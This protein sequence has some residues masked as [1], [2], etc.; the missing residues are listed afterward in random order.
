LQQLRVHW[1]SEKE[2]NI[3]FITLRSTAKTKGAL[4]FYIGFANMPQ[5]LNVCNMEKKLRFIEN[6]EIFNQVAIVLVK[7]CDL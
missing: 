4:Q 5:F 6:K 7:F 2:T 3:Q 1:Y